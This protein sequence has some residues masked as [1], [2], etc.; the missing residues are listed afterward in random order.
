MITA[1]SLFS[2]IGGIDIAFMQAGFDVIWA[3]EADKFACATYR[4][5]FANKLIEADIR[6]VKAEDIPKA[7]VLFGG[8]PCQSFSIMGYRRGFK[9]PRGN[10]FF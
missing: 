9:D 8:F 7:D 5:N 6:T 1:V 3:N 2:G 10:L 4:N